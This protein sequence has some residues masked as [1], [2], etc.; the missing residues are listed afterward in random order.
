LRT[1]LNYIDKVSN[2]KAKPSER[3]GQKAADLIS[4]RE[5]AELPMGDILEARP[6]CFNESIKGRGGEKR[7][8][9][10]A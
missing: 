3:R 6:F 10:P 4:K 5:M 8:E 9:E 1:C 7:Y 2:E